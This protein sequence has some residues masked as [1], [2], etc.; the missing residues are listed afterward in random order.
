M[1]ANIIILSL[2][3]LSLGISL[4]K[5]GQKKKVK[6]HNGWTALIALIVMWILYYYAGIF[7]FL[8]N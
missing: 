6:K 1:I 7:D 4:G 8:L 3:I 2:G 5:H